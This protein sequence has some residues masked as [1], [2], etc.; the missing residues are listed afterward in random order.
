MWLQQVATTLT[1]KTN[2]LLVIKSVRLDISCRVVAKIWSKWITFLLVLMWILLIIFPLER[3][4]TFLLL[5]CCVKLFWYGT[6]NFLLSYIWINICWVCEFQAWPYKCA[7][8]YLIL[9]YYFFKCKFFYYF[10]LRYWSPKGE[11]P[12][13]CI[14]SSSTTTRIITPFCF[15]S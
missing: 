9:K 11:S 10:G 4:W 7:S 1:H 8:K 13:G 15:V 3:C 6:N 14:H 12:C 2:T 5:W